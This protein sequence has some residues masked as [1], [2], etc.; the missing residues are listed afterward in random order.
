MADYIAEDGLINLPLY[1]IGEFASVVSKA[2]Q[3]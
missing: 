2:L 1:A 3:K